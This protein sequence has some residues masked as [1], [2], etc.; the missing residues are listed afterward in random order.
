MRKFVVFACAISIATSNPAIA[1]PKSIAVK[2]AIA[3]ATN[4][5]TDGLASSGENLIAFTSTSSATLDIT[6]A[7]KNSTGAD[8]W[9]KVIDSGQNELATVITGDSA[10]NIW[11]GGSSASVPVAAT[12]ATQSSAANPDGVSIETL[13]KLRKDMD[14]ISI[15]QLSPNGDLMATFTFPLKEAA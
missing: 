12:A 10:G 11:L 6:V 7:A 14:Q 8:I 9:S 5:Q 2:D 15:W 13:S 4:I 1:A 3:L